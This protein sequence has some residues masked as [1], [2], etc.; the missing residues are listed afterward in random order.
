[1]TL[2]SWLAHFHQSSPEIPKAFTGFWQLF[3]F[4]VQIKLMRLFLF[5]RSFSINRISNPSILALIANGIFLGP[6][7]STISIQKLPFVRCAKRGT[8]STLFLPLYLPQPDEELRWALLLLMVPSFFHLV[9]WVQLTSFLEVFRTMDLSGA[10]S[11][12]PQENFNFTSRFISSGATWFLFMSLTFFKLVRVVVSKYRP[13]HDVQQ[14]ARMENR[15]GLSKTSKISTCSAFESQMEISC[16]RTIVLSDVF[17]CH[18][19]RGFWAG[20]S[21]P[22]AKFFVSR[23]S[24]L[25]AF[26]QHAPFFYHYIITFVA[27]S[28]AGNF[29][30]SL[31]RAQTYFFTFRA[32]DFGL[33]SLEGTEDL[34]PPIASL[35]ARI[36]Y[37][38]MCNNWIFERFSR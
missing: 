35:L 25:H 21:F 20:F 14:R 6:T 3:A 19:P 24:T 8:G 9:V 1:M 7:H 38:A 10:K 17:F 37:S 2:F 26:W 30:P 31:P 4:V 27:S 29:S 32:G 16:S 33:A 18:F 23:N 11:S 12:K 13:Y 28:S 5:T 36:A 34:G 15:V 22:K